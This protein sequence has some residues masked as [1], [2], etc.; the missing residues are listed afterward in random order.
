MI[1][2]AL[3]ERFPTS[4]G[5]TIIRARGKKISIFM[6]GRVRERGER[7]APPRLGSM[8]NWFRGGARKVCQVGSLEVTVGPQGGWLPNFLDRS[9]AERKLGNLGILG[10]QRFGSGQKKDMDPAPHN[11]PQE[12]PPLFAPG[13]LSGSSGRACSRPMAA[14]LCRPVMSVYES[15]VFAVITVT[16]VRFQKAFETQPPVTLKTSS[17]KSR[18]QAMTQ[19]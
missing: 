1:L 8:A 19:A 3:S 7:R 15:R 5:F 2:K 6:R 12:K 11:T 16:R 10:S 14:I 18:C 9:W 13:S 4:I 17:E